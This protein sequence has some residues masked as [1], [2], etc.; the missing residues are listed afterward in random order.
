M[1]GMT[2][3]E[4]MKLI[5]Q[6]SFALVECNLFLDSHPKNSEALEYFEKLQEKLADFTE[7]Y[8]EKYGPL[9]VYGSCGDS[10]SWVTAPW[11]W[12]ASE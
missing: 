11:P 8:E 4:L 1:N 3:K 2:K 12:E 6:Y 10:W 7:E 5:Q 9:T